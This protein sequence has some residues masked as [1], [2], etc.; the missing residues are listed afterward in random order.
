MLIVLFSIKLGWLPSGGAETIASGL[1]GWISRRS[2]A[3][4]GPAGA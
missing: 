3:P 1:T 2:P 4:H